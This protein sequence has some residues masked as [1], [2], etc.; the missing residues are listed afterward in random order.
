VRA[1][2]DSEDLIGGSPSMADVDQVSPE[3][4]EYE[5]DFTVAREAI[6]VAIAVMAVVGCALLSELIFIGFA[7]FWGHP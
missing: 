6:V 3:A 4:N 7:H 1:Q 2:I 5:Q